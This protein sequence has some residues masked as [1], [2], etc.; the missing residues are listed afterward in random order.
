MYVY[1]EFLGGR[2]AF[3]PSHCTSCGNKLKWY[4]LFPVF[5]Y[6]ALGRKCRFC[7]EKISIRYM[8]VELFTGIMYLM[9]YLQFGFSLN[10]IKFIFLIT[11]LI[12]IGLID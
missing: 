3:P 10:T 12:I 11:M 8:I 4:D 9:V 1:I 5:S 2:I 7:K 6:L